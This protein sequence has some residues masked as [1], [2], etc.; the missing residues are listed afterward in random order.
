MFDELLEGL[1]DDG[2]QRLLASMRRRRLRR[3]EVLFWE[4][5]PA[6]AAFL[7]DSGHLLVERTSMLG[8]VC[9]VAV[10]GPGDLVG[11]QALLSDEPRTATVRTIGPTQ[12]RVLTSTAFAA[13]RDDHPTFDALLIELL[14]RRL[15]AVSELL[16]E[17]RTAPVE[18]RVRST[19]VMAR[20][21]FGDE[22]PLSQE[23]LASLAGTTRQ[24]VNAVLGDLQEDGVIETRRGGLRVIDPTRL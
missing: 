5:D 14:D 17:A 24:T 21:H 6:D 8:D 22:I 2:R 3:G 12:L 4:G 18:D 1:D 10:V 15:R 20:C 16:F 9:A 23:I 7:V 11:E 13:L 19:I